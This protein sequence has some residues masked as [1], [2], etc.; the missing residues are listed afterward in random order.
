LREAKLQDT[1][2][3]TGSDDHFGRLG[4]GAPELVAHEASRMQR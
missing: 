3:R 2:Q 1:I 4:L